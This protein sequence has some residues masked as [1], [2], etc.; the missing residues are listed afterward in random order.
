MKTTRFPL[1]FPAHAPSPQDAP[2]LFLS[3]RGALDS[4]RSRG[5]SRTTKI[6]HQG[7]LHE[8]R[9]ETLGQYFTPEPISRFMWSL[10]QPAID[11]TV[12]STNRRCRIIDTSCGSGRLLAHASL[13]QCL[14]DGA[15]VDGRL[16]ERLSGAAAAWGLNSVFENACMSEFRFSGYSAALINPP[17]SIQL[18][19]P[20]MEPL[21]CTAH[22]KFGPNTSAVSHQYALDQALAGADL[23]CALLPLTQAANLPAHAS[24]RL[25]ARFD[26]P[27]DTF[28]EEN[29]RVST[30][31]CL[32][33][34][35][36]WAGAA[37]H[38][39]LDTV[40][41]CGPDF[42]LECRACPDTGGRLRVTG[43]DYSE[44]VITL[45]VTGNPS[46]RVFRSGRN[47]R[48]GFFCGFTQA[49]VM[50][51][52][53]RSVIPYQ[54]GL[55]RPSGWDYLGDGPFDLH[56]HLVQPDPMASFFEWVDEIRQAGG[57]PLV[58]PCLVNWLRRK[59]EYKRRVM[60]PPE[61]WVL[62][63]DGAG[64]SLV[65]VARES[66]ML[67]PND[68]ASL[69]HFGGTGCLGWANPRIWRGQP[70]YGPPV[71]G[72]GRHEHR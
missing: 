57:S 26:L 55:R 6:R 65:G 69:R 40:P 47:I 33:A 50:N 11:R 60:V 43:V 63:G 58:E 44:P 15:D 7:D 31:V 14:I 30:S 10:V 17:F 41:D 22:G 64:S 23:V 8:A 42:G 24:A 72:M 9:A 21:P 68:W 29:A 27:A 2:A 36:E 52:L 67:D 45:P 62:S 39:R 1:D 66:F 19:S 59:T 46:V 4:V 61:R 12:R 18:S 28:S 48:L 53:L 3:W 34:A 49:K 32:F 25:V 70:Q 13:D 51:A 16:V 56:V 54:D 20:A 37:H 5:S 35:S 71:P 38:E